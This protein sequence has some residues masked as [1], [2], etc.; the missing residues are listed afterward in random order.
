MRVLCPGAEGVGCWCPVL[1][2]GGVS[3][4]LRAWLS[5]APSQDGGTAT[6]AARPCVG[7]RAVDEA[8]AVGAVGAAGAGLCGV[9][10]LGVW[11]PIGA[12]SEP[13]SPPGPP[14]GDGAPSP[15]M[16]GGDVPVSCLAPA[17]GGHGGPS[18]ARGLPAVAITQRWSLGVVSG[19]SASVCGEGPPHVG[20]GRGG[21]SPSP[22]LCGSTCTERFRPRRGQTPSHHTDGVR[23]TDGPSLGPAA[24]SAPCP[25]CLGCWSP[26]AAPWRPHRRSAAH[27]VR[28][29]RWPWC[30]GAV[31]QPW[32]AC[33]ARTQSGSILLPALCCPDAPMAPSPCPCGRWQ[34]PPQAPT[35]NSCGA[36]NPEAA[37]C[38]EETSAASD[39]L[40][41][42]SPPRGV[43]GGGGAAEQ[44]RVCAA[45][46][47]R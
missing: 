31:A 1:G 46:S 32:A 41:V 40:R 21:V 7:T 44:G 28:C 5:A 19:L 16:A 8:G 6:S 10:G 27:A 45:W 47:P 13:G 33:A 15:R 30:P 34:P 26:T 29:W 12:P 42:P 37:A 2:A 43:L 9:G 36:A 4:G 38:E 22:R 17:V 20:R 18:P 25:T 35:P 23:G 3:E 24:G 14:V 11:G 39:G